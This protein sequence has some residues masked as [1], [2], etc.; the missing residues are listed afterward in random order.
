V[1]MKGLRSKQYTLNLP[2]VRR[3]AAS[4]SLHFNRTESEVL[5]ARGKDET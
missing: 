5:G 2:P 1:V 4:I 3:A